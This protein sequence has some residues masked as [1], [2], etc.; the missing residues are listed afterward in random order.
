M[1]RKF[2][3][4]LKHAKVWTLTSFSSWGGIHLLQFWAPCHHGWMFFLRSKTT[5]AP[6]SHVVF[7]LRYFWHWKYPR[8]RNPNFRL[9]TKAKGLQGCGPR[10]SLE[11]TSHTSGSVGK[12]EG[13]NPHTPKAT[14][15]LGNVIPVDSRNFIERFRGQNSMSCGVFYIIGK[16]LKRKCVKWDCIAHLDIWN[17]SYG[18]KKGQ[19]SNWQFDSWP[20]KVRNRSNF[21]ACRW[22]ATYHW[23]ALNEG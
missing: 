2:C 23:K 13:V 14:P 18:Q 7:I 10:E 15:T 1:A 21:H 22:C 11:V 6:R 9:V 4:A 20:L 16:F 19:E 17:T 5:W 3:C 12:C 8:C